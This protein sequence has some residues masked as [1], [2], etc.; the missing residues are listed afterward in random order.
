MNAKIS[1][2]EYFTTITIL[3][4]CI[5]WAIYDYNNDELKKI[6]FEPIIA[7][8]SSVSTFL[9]Y[10]LLKKKNDTENSESIYKFNSTQELNSGTIIKDSKN[11]ANNSKL[12]A[13]GNIHI[14]DK[15]IIIKGGFFVLLISIPLI[16]F[17]TKS[18]EPSYLTVSLIDKSPNPNIQLEKT[19]ITL[20]YNGKRESQFVKEEA[21][22]SGIPSNFKGENIS[23]Q[24]ESEGFVTIDTSIELS[25]NNISIPLV[26][27]KSLSRMFGFIKDENG[28]PISDAN[29][30]IQ[31]IDTTSTTSGYFQL[32]IP[33]YK[34][35][36]SQRLRIFKKGF[37]IWDNESPVLENEAIEVILINL[38]NN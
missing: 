33:T 26:R 17:R 36:K 11:I 14:G 19:K 28:N 21:T 4:F 37:K 2:L 35:R 38:K 16:L 6:P 8:V 31:N 10:L 7:I 27:D 12:K 9:G 13:H 24:I 29:V 18:K 32:N 15:V 20:N 23:L 3:I 1:F 30:S 34:Q 22:F 5:C 25:K